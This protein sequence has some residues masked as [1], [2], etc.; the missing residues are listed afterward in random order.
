MKLWQQASAV[1]ARYNLLYTWEFNCMATL[2]VNKLSLPII[3]KTKSNYLIFFLVG[4]RNY[5]SN[6]ET[7][8]CKITCYGKPKKLWCKNCNRFFTPW[9]FKIIASLRCRL[10]VTLCI[11]FQKVW[12]RQVLKGTLL[13]K[14]FANFLFL[15]DYNL[16]APFKR[17][18]TVNTRDSLVPLLLEL[19]QMSW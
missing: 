13:D 10:W 17:A 7:Q 16:K 9:P 6:M 2:R 18:N 1:S 19:A 12:P 3:R 14:L 11:F 8:S 4:K 5:S 15:Y